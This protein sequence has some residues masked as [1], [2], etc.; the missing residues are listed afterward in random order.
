MVFITAGMAVEQNRAAPVIARVARELDILTVGI[1]TI[2]FAFEAKKK[3][4]AEEGLEELRKSVDTL[5][6]IN[7]DRLREMYGNLSLGNAFSQAD[8]VLAIA[9]R[10]C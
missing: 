1:V 9:Q 2:P 4:Q 5:L 7:N 8:N 10:N 6:I 3:Q